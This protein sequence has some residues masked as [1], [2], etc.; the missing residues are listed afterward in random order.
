MTKLEFIAAFKSACDTLP[1][2]LLEAALADYERQFTDQLLSGLSEQTIV[3]RWG[4][5]QHA[6]LKLKLGTFNGNLKQAVSAEKVAR[7]GLSGVGLILM[8]FFLLIPATLYFSLLSV[9]YA[10][11]LV[12]YLTGIFV[13]ASSLAG[14]SFIDIP[15][16]RIPNFISMH[17]TTHLDLND[18][19]IVPTLISSA[20]LP[21]KAMEERLL[22]F[23]HAHFLHDQG[24][25]IATNLNKNTL[26]NGIGITLAG[27]LLMLCCFLA[28]RFTFRMLRRFAAWHF[29][30]LKNA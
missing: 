27:M 20:D 25:H 23:N 7:V 24:L 14:V 17:G 1:S 6:A 30:V 18:I 29:S 26:W 22:G 28:T 8:D 12:A 3:E 19:E 2:E 5:P 16:H 10:L 13:S 11:A 15:A 4:S 21:T 9:F